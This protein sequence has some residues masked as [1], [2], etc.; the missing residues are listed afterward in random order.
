MELKNEAYPTGRIVASMGMLL[1][2]FG[3]LIVLTTQPP[4][5]LESGSGMGNYRMPGGG[6]ATTASAGTTGPS[7]ASS[8]GNAAPTTVVV[9]TPIPTNS[10]NDNSL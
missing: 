3:V 2:V 1:L 5:V 8:S 7:A 9:D 6:Y 10:T 4:S